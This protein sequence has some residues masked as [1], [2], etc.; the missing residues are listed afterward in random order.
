MNVACRHYVCLYFQI[1][2]NFAFLSVVDS[3]LGVHAPALSIIDRPLS[4]LTAVMWVVSLLTAPSYCPVVVKLLS[5]I[6]LM[7]AYQYAPLVVN[8]PIE[9]WAAGGFV[10]VTV[11]HL[12]VSR[13]KLIITS[14]IILY[15]TLICLKMGGLHVAS[16]MYRGLLA[17]H[18]A[19]LLAAFGVIMVILCCQHDPV[20]GSVL[21]GSFTAS[22]LSVLI[23]QPWLLL[24]SYAYSA[25]L[26]QGLA[27]ALSREQ[28]TLLKLQH[29]S[30]RAQK[31]AHEWGHV[32]FFPN[33]LLHS[34]YTSV[35]KS[36]SSS[37][38][39]SHKKKA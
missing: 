8:S 20:K 13:K 1:F 19:T 26:L 24:L 6:H 21:F 37:I 25:S 35:T 16:S 28:P 12:L 38:K 22:T 39:K 5:L 15:V 17:E 33:L 3:A 27:H 18:T 11:L 36:T 4:T 14:E 30:D 10:V 29:D 7:L 32:V 23:D 2:S 34:I 31:V 9:L